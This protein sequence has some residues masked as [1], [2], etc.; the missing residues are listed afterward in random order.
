MK[1]NKNQQTKAQSLLKGYK[2]QTAIPKEIREH[3]AKR[4]GPSYIKLLKQTGKYT[5]FSGIFL[6]IYF[7]LKKLLYKTTIT[8]IITAM[9]LSSSIAIGSYMSVL[10]FSKSQ[11]FATRNIAFSELLLEHDSSKPAAV[12]IYKLGIEPIQ[13]STVT[14]ATLY[15]TSRLL[16]NRLRAIKGKSFATIIPRGKTSGLKYAVFSSAEQL[17]SA[18]I[19]YVKVVRLQDSSIVHISK[20]TAKDTADIPKIINSIAAAISSK[21]P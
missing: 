10:E 21:T 8:N 15:K 20:K 9:V 3:M 7:G 18:I 4:L 16:R 5:I 14:R 11:A 17:D 2:M 19:L 1:K 12:I 6:T 13:S